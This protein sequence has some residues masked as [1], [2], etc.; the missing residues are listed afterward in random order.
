MSLKFFSSLV[1]IFFISC[2]T[3]PIKYDR[4]IKANDYKDYYQLK[5]QKDQPASKKSI[6]QKV[7]EVFIKKP[8]AKTVEVQQ[9]KTNKV[10]IKRSRSLIPTRRI[11]KTNIAPV[12]NTTPVLL[13][14][15][16][17]GDAEVSHDIGKTIMLY[18]IYLQALIIA[19]FA[20]AILKHRKKI[21]TPT[22][23]TGELNL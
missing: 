19:I 20:Y 5:E 10:E 17:P 1:L 4:P 13:A 11:R 14:N 3:T 16:R 7:K 2:S 21:K 9:T 6:G 23:K 8:K 12:T 15:T 18:L 22:R